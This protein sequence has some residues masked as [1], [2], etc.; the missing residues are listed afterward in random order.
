MTIIA[1]TIEEALALSKAVAAE[2]ATEERRARRRR[3]DV[4]A[5]P[6]GDKANG[7]N[8]AGHAPQATSST[9]TTNSGGSPMRPAWAT[10]SAMAAYFDR[11][12]G[13]QRRVIHVIANSRGRMSI[14]DIKTALGL[15]DR[16]ETSIL[17][18]RCAA[19][20]KA[21]GLDWK[22][23]APFEIKG[24]RADRTSFYWAGPLLRGTA[25]P[26]DMTAVSGKSVQ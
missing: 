6:P 24:A 4:D 18:S 22:E 19:I 3:V 25:R 1:D 7:V 26:E 15:P 5:A 21:C 12:S 2:N 10:S 13:G 11:L 9:A 14:D 17:V 8:G 20:A 23:I 16:R